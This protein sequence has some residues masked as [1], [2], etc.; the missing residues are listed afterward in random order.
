MDKRWPAHNAATG[1]LVGY[2]VRKELPDGTKDMYWEGVSGNPGLNGFPTKDMALYPYPIEPANEIVVVEGQKCADALR[3]K[4]TPTHGTVCGS[5]VC[6]GDDA[7]RPLVESGRIVLWPDNDDAGRKHMSEIAQRLQALGAATNLYTVSWADASEKGDC[8]D[9]IVQ[10]VDVGALIAE[11]EPIPPAPEISQLL[12]RIRGF[13]KR[14]IFIS[15]KE[16]DTLALWV[17]HTWIFQHSLYTPYMNIHS[18]EKDSGKT[19]LLDVLEGIVNNGLAF[20]S[21]TVAS[22]RYTINES[23]PTVLYDETDVAIRGD[24]DDSLRGLLNNG[25]R[26][27]RGHRKMVG[28]GGAG[29][30]TELDIFCPKAFAGL[31]RLFKTVESRSIPIEMKRATHAEFR[32]LERFIAPLIEDECQA[33]RDDLEAWGQRTSC[34]DDWGAY[35]DL[36]PELNNRKADIWVPLYQIAKEAG[37]GWPERC[38][39]AAIALSLGNEAEE[40]LGVM[41]LSDIKTLFD[42]SPDIDR[43]K[44]KDIVEFLTVL[45]ERPWPDYKE[46]PSDYRGKSLTPRRMVGLLAR[47]GIAP[48]NHRMPDGTT[49]KGYLRTDFEDAWSRYPSEKGNNVNKSPEPHY[50]HVDAVNPSGDQKSFEDGMLTDVQ[51]G[52]SASTPRGAVVVNVVAADRDNSGI[53]EDDKGVGI[54][55]ETL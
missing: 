7:L 1:D 31:E 36:P 11:A 3:D 9:A 8:A 6:P 2:H 55:R 46:N 10:G 24:Q 15:S 5:A 45:E 49:R 21:T 14:F 20:G 27:G 12:N 22:L 32:Q 18:A 38:I 16:T 47:Y 50:V 52:S 37:H 23:H 53:D 51:S 4:G 25:F 41:L 17:M 54:T 40:S 19:L 35:T 13:I 28:H 44:S 26:K 48:R 30:S 34:Y 33:L 39:A 42:T 29:G 43:L